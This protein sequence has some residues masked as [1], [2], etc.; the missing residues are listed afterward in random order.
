MKVDL[1]RYA[2]E[3][4][5]WE[6]R[7]AGIMT[8][9]KDTAKR[10]KDTRTLETNLSDLEANEPEG[11]K[12][13]HVLFGDATPEALA[14]KLANGWPVGGVLSSEAGIVFGGHAM[15]KDSAMR[16][17]ALLNSMWGA[18]RVTID[19]KTGPS[20][21]SSGRK[22]DDGPCSSKRDCEGFP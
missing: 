10:G 14:F 17:M 19:R 3:R 21:A 4:Q 16:N 13:P 5:A 6:A 9:I 2:A 8:A 12:V 22:A 11:P 15:G 18:E 7:K 20:F 1:K